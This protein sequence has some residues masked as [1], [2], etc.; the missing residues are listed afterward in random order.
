MPIQGVRSLVS[1]AKEIRDEQETKPSRRQSEQNCAVWSSF[2]L[3]WFGFGS[4]NEKSY[5]N[6]SV[7]S[8]EVAVLNRTKP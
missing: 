6:G 2:L 5:A 7:Y 4:Q 8:F 1:I 3:E